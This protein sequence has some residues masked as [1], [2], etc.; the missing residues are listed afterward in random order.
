MVA[1]LDFEDVGQKVYMMVLTLVDAMASVR[2]G[3]K[4]R[5]QVEV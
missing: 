3:A 2:V 1:L 4:A 5:L